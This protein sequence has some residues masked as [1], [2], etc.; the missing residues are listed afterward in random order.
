MLKIRVP[1]HVNGA[2]LSTTISRPAL[3][4]QSITRTPAQHTLSLQRHSS[5]LNKD[6]TSP[7]SRP[8]RRLSKES[9]FT[10]RR[11]ER[12][13]RK[14]ISTLALDPVNS[15]FGSFSKTPQHPQEDQHGSGRNSDLWT[16]RYRKLLLWSIVL[17][18]PIW[19]RDLVEAVVPGALGMIIM[20]AGKIKQGVKRVRSVFK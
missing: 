6:S 19:G 18:L 9:W 4:L 20:G 11:K 17:T 15:V 16:R 5:F 10:R 8:V 2:A 7:S 12:T 13:T 3:L 1:A 14:K